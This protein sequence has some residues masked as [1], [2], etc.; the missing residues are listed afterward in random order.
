MSRTIKALLCAVG[1]FVLVLCSK[2]G[3][4]VAF[5]SAV[6]VGILAF[7]V[8]DSSNSDEY[9]EYS[10]RSG[11]V[12][13]HYHQTAVPQLRQYDENFEPWSDY[14]R[15]TGAPP[16]KLKKKKKKGKVLTPVVM[17]DGNSQAMRDLFDTLGR[18]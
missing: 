5:A 11:G 10:Q 1:I 17:Y 6:L 7:F 18:R 16:R 8:L 15:L 2:Q 3:A 12:H 9:N 4:D 14:A 13:Y